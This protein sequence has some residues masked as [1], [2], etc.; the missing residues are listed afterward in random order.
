MTGSGAATARS[1]CPS[2]GHSLCSRRRG[3]GRCGCLDRFVCCQL[4]AVC[5]GCK[6][7]GTG[8]NR[9]RTNYM[10][11]VER[12]LVWWWQ[13]STSPRS[14]SACISRLLRSNARF[15]PSR[16]TSYPGN[17]LPKARAG[18]AD[19]VVAATPT[20]AASRVWES[21]ERRDAS[22]AAGF[23]GRVHLSS[24]PSAVL[25]THDIVIISNTTFM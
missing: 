5:S 17:P 2:A 16:L 14:S 24:T 20:A 4:C 22:T 21:S 11:L 12:E 7:R 23:A 6:V 13:P 18:W 8:S 10:Q 25:G 1:S 15:L 9:I 19:P 3:A